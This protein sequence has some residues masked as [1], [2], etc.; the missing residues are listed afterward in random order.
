MARDVA[1]TNAM[2]SGFVCFVVNAGDRALAERAAADAF[3]MGA[4]GLEERD[5]EPVAKL[6]FYAPRNRAA[7]VRTALLAHG[8]EPAERAVPAENWSESWKA[9]LGPVEVSERLRVRPSFVRAPLLPGQVELRI[10]PGQAFGTGGHESTLLALEWV[11][12]LAPL[13]PTTRVLDVGCGTGVLALAALGLG[14]GRAV[15]FDL[16]R[17]AAQAASDNAVRN[18]LGGRLAVF[19]GSIAASRVVGFDLVLANLLRDEMLPQLTEVAARTAPGGRIVL[20]GLLATDRSELEPALTRCGL[21]IRDAR[22]RR[23]ASGTAWLALLTT[24]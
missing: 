3:E 17:L 2:S 24:R 14:A 1:A 23:D 8:L 13:P 21:R 4:V 19:T 10:D 22:T 5:G 9:G 16:D 18:G 11:D 6:I 20:S 7:A 15:A 12:A